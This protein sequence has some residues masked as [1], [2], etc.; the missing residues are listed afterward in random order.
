MRSRL[1]EEEGF[2]RESFTLLR[3]D[4]RAK[5]REIL[6]RDPTGGYSTTV[7]FWRQLKDGQIEFTI[8]RLPTA[9]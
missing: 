7:E 9:D 8:R 2:I 6:A 5:A 1:K 3:A 4:A